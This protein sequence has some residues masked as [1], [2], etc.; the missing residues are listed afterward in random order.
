MSKVL[1]NAIN[2]WLMRCVEACQPKLNY[3]IDVPC[4]HAE[5][6]MFIRC[7]FGLTELRL[8]ADGQGAQIVPSYAV[9]K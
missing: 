1:D 2:E 5:A 9:E 6:R 8:V 3:R 7:G 4:L